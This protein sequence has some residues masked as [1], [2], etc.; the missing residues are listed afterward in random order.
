MG[1]MTILLGAETRCGG[2]RVAGAGDVQV[3]GALRWERRWGV[4]SSDRGNDNKRYGWGP[5]A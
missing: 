4:G 2:W 3:D 5:V 1:Y